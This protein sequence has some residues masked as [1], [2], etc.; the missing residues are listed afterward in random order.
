MWVIISV[1]PPW[2]GPHVGRALGGTSA[3][4][5]PLVS[6][7]VWKAA[8]RSS[9]CCAE[10]RQGVPPGV[11]QAGAPGSEQGPSHPT[12]PSGILVNCMPSGELC[13][14][15]PCKQMLLLISSRYFH[16]ALLPPRLSP[17]SW[18]WPA[19]CVLQPCLSS[20]PY[21]CSVH[22]TYYCTSQFLNAMLCLAPAPLHAL[23]PFAWSLPPSFHLLFQWFSAR[24]D[25]AP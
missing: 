14:S 7:H 19:C 5:A 12:F 2:K 15:S 1:P 6:I 25:A 17:N 18:E 20:V 3:L 8:P 9:C 23:L 22:Q 4:S 16:S 13:S 21:G 11:H 10:R 24:G